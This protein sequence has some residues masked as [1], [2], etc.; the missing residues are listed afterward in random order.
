MKE[1]TILGHEAVG[2]VEKVGKGVRNF[3]PGDRV[4]I[5]STIACGWCA[6]CRAGYYANCDESNPGGEGTAFFGGPQENGG[7]DGLQSELARVPFAN[8][9]MVRLPGDVTDDQALLLSDVFPTGYFA[10]ELAE[11]KKGDTVAV[12]GCG[13]VGQFAVVSARLLGAARVFAVDNVE[14]RLEQAREQGAEVIDF[15]RED[16][17]KVIRELTGG[18]GVDR[19]ID[20]VGVDSYKPRGGPAARG[21]RKHDKHFRA[22][23]QELGAGQG[24]GVHPGDAPSEAV[25][26]AVE[27]LA[28][29]G[30]LGIVGVYPGDVW[31]PLGDSVEKDLTIKLGN[32]PQR[33]YIPK[34]LDLIRS[35]V[36]DPAAV[37][38]QHQPLTS[39]AEAYKA[40]EERRPG[41]LKVELSPGL[42]RV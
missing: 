11:I 42:A 6:Y 27:A 3:K 21:A 33:R 14:S 35:G 36:V 34:L 19:A 41:W 7:Y 8:V 24:K 29:A 10:A 13:P 26:W 23:V 25:H 31:F 12:F 28:K 2:V 30:T 39:A 9:G 20:A 4:V 32:C 22:E 1:G 37:V 17:V 15:D 38:T 40:F 16:P 5:A 18:I